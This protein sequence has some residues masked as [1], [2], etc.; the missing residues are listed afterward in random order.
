MA[1]IVLSSR[2]VERIQRL[3]LGIE[4][5]DALRGARIS[6]AIRITFDE[7]PLGLRRPEIVRHDSAAFALLYES[8]MEETIVIRLFD[9]LQS[10]WT[11]FGDRRRFVPRRLRIPLLAS[12]TADAQPVAQRIRQPA[13][14]PGAAY[15]A[16]ECQTGMRGRVTRDDAAVRW[17][18]VQAVDLVTGATVGRAHCDDRGEFF[19]LIDSTASGLAELSNP[20]ELQ[21][22]VHTPNTPAVSSAVQALDALWDLPIEEVPPPGD[23]DT[24]SAGN[25]PW[26]QWTLAASINVQFAL[27]TILRGHAA[28]AV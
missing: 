2:F 28:L 6:Q 18:R 11:E 14:F 16:V 1:N 21:L 13:L 25:L 12:A 10:T 26:L 9:A 17:A 5:I 15:D 19:L 7:V 22:R 20:L 23:A 27:G 4:A 24:V 3:A 8:G